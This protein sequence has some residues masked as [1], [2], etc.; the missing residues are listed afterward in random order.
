MDVTDFLNGLLNNK[1]RA[2]DL[3]ESDGTEII[4]SDSGNKITLKY[5]GLNFYNFE[6]SDANGKLLETTIEKV[7]DKFFLRESTIFNTNESSELK[8][9]YYKEYKII[10]SQNKADS[11]KDYYIH[12]HQR[13]QENLFDLM[14]K[15]RTYWNSFDL[16]INKL[17]RF[18]RNTKTGE[19]SDLEGI[20]ASYSELKKAV[21]TMLNDIICSTEEYNKSTAPEFVIFSCF[22]KS[23]TSLVQF[24]IPD[25]EELDLTNTN[26]ENF[27][28][29]LNLKISDN[30]D[31]ENFA[32]VPTMTSSH[33]SLMFIDL[34]KNIKS[35]NRIK[36][37]DN[38]LAHYDNTT[39]Q[40]ILKT[41]IFGSLADK[42][43]ILN[44]IKPQFGG[45]CGILI[46]HNLEQISQVERDIEKLFDDIRSGKFQT[47]MI[48]DILRDT[49]GIYVT[50]NKTNKIVTINGYESSNSLNLSNSRKIPMIDLKFFKSLLQKNGYII[51]N[52]NILDETIKCQK[53]NLLNLY[54]DK[55]SHIVD[56]MNKKI[57]C[58]SE[59]SL[60]PFNKDNMI[61]A[62]ILMESSKYQIRL[63]EESL[64]DKIDNINGEIFR[65]DKVSM[66]NS[67]I[68]KK[69]MDNFKTF[70][71]LKNKYQKAFK[72]YEK[73]YQSLISIKNYTDEQP[74]NFEK[75]V[76]IYIELQDKQKEIGLCYS[77]LFEECYKRLQESDNCLLNESKVDLFE[78]SKDSEKPKYLKILR[79]N[80][81]IKIDKSSDGKFVI[82]LNTKNLKLF[83]DI[84]E[85]KIHL[86]NNIKEI[87]DRFIDNLSNKISNQGFTNDIIDLK[88]IS[89]KRLNS[90]HYEP[91]GKFINNNIM[92]N[93]KK[94]NSM[95]KTQT[96]FREI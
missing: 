23:L 73:I 4:L 60:I 70:N 51:N 64:K 90:S 16:N 63:F 15:D 20:D 53:M 25:F 72:E 80:I 55:F 36:H 54:S 3:I 14:T 27:I 56:I 91:M 69:I 81:P 94:I 7:G 47:K 9:I 68:N 17:V 28:R 67:E 38:S 34:R 40:L 48:T 65:D 92:S 39:G 35:E 45:C 59:I 46:N 86:S 71:E 18:T 83:K 43:E 29:S 49:Y 88:R 8:T 58:L 30:D 50:G 44:T 2:N 26:T 24:R 87:D 84:E 42:I 5:N 41:E 74:D 57:N 77:K 96:G 32:I 93:Y 95:E 11:N 66:K 61:K 21:N 10:S 33:I 1:S 78:N 19:I 76:D 79:E 52:E 89:I 82:S 12:K 75:N 62:I 22:L 6:V 13:N 85:V 31:P 37:L